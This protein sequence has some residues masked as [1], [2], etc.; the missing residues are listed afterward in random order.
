MQELGL[1]ARDALRGFR[2][3]QDHPR[4]WG[5]I[6]APALV[7]LVVLI[8]SIAGVVALA[9]PLIDRISDLAP[10]W[11]AGWVEGLLAIL[12][13][14]ALGL[15]G[16]LVF[17]SFAGV[18]AGPFNELLS[19]AVERTL[20]GAPGERFSLA[21]FVRG[22]LVG[23]VHGLRR[24]LVFLLGV[25]VV[26]AIAFIPVIGAIAAPLLGGYLAARGA[27]YDCYDAVLA[28]RER[29]YAQKQAFLQAHRGRTLGLGAVVAGLLL[30][31]GVNLV[32][33]GVGAIGAT[34][35]EREL[36]R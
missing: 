14:A 36:A 9:S 26:F 13:V 32:A 29:T 15:G 35:A 16:L 18:V 20:T 27:A 7:T 5:W 28:R 24:L 11:L 1:G 2:F 21:G 33:L 30:V 12:V 4:L 6:L 31:P 17:V 10:G 23:L 3:L 34:L 8:A 22:A 19:E 25:L